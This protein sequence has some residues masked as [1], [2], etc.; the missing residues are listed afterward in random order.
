MSQ[1]TVKSILVVGAGPAGL[2]T[3]KTFLHHPAT[4]SKFNVTIFEAAERVG[5]MWR[6]TADEEGDKCS[7]HMRT[8]L[9]RFTV[10]F[11]D[12]PWQDVKLADMHGFSKPD[13]PPMFPK[14]HQVGQYLDA[15]AKKYI[16]S[17]VLVLNRK[18]TAT[19]LSSRSNTNARIW[20]V[21]SFDC[22]AKEE[23]NDTFD[24]IIVASGFFD[25]ASGHYGGLDPAVEPRILHSSKFREV[26][27]LVQLPGDI[28]VVGG[29]ISG[30]EAAATAAGQ[31]ADARY[32]PSEEEH[33]AWTASKIYHIANRPFYCLPRYLPIDPYDASI[34]SY[35]LSPY[36]LPLDL[37][38][39]NLS[40]RGDGPIHAANGQV[41]PEKAKKAHDYIRSL[42]G[43]DQRDVAG[44]HLASKPNQTELPAFTGI[45]DTYMEFVRS[46]VIVP[47]RG[48]ATAVRQGANGLLE[49]EA[50]Q[51]EPWKL[52]DKQL[53]ILTGIAG[54][55]GATGFQVHLDYLPSEVKQALG[56]DPGNER[57]PFL[58][59]HGSI[60]NPEVPELAFVGFYEGP[61][62]GVMEMQARLV[63]HNWAVGSLPQQYAE[64]EDVQKSVRKA[65][66]DR[67]NDVAQFWMGDY[68][69]LVDEFARDL[70]LQRKDAGFGGQKGPIFP[71]RYPGLEP[72]QSSV[73]QE[74]LDLL[75]DSQN[76]C[77]FVPAAA[78]RAM[79][80][81]WDLKRKIDSRKTTS[82]GGTFQGTAQFNPR[83]P[84]DSAFSAEY[85]YIETGAFT[86]DNGYAFPTSKRYIYRFCEVDDEISAWFV[87]PDNHTVERIFHT[88][89][90]EP[91]N[92]KEKGW[93]AKGTHWC[94]PDDYTSSYEFRF[95]GA[96]LHSFGISY[97]V[98]GPQKDYTTDAWY[99]RPVGGLDLD[100]LE[101]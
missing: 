38:L 61:Y 35:N 68:V 42:A 23:H 34:Q 57:V 39:Y 87:L 60:S 88:L 4:T 91:P 56:Y 17:E 15:Y 82:P 75:S 89:T 73:I 19:K 3:A 52:T 79:Q 29:G 7:P 36:F 64:V 2:V 43:G 95:R 70:H 69:G 5:G 63:A 98:V 30:S 20:E 100:K 97:D 67:L 90:F 93:L 13:H 21:A 53:T 10:A 22:V 41:P 58:L 32:K 1:N 37:V 99:T 8:N 16:R 94:D 18:V 45:S 47:V 24:Y 12:L 71:A 72:N 76:K 25:R 51:Q 65:T 77:R 80:G 86:M 54:V 14:A 9:S 11:S 78:F 62:W 84:T 40:R 49:V 33:P 66:T 26:N 83:A 6:A 46:G 27:Q 81:I 101:V 44:F 31:L 96:N 59:S 48:R 74:V 55:I 50:H 92:N 28:V 85:L